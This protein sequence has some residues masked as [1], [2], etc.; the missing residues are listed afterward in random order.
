MNWTFEVSRE[1]QAWANGIYTLSSHAQR[2]MNARRL[3]RV[4]LEQVLQYG[5]VM[6]TRGA[7]IFV[8][9]SREAEKPTS[10]RCT[11]ERLRGL[12][13]VASHDRTIVTVYRNHDFRSLKNRGHSLSGRR[14]VLAVAGRAGRSWRPTRNR[15]PIDVSRT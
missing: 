6:P 15:G 7:W 10:L 5:R 11:A 12:Q 9:G 4:E 8:F 13:V 14:R 1:S 3:S 2:R